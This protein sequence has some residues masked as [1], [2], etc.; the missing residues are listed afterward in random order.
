MANCRW[1]QQ[2]ARRSCGTFNDTTGTCG[3]TSPVI[4]RSVSVAGPRRIGS[5]SVGSATSGAHRDGVFTWL[6]PAVVALPFPVRLVIIGVHHAE[7]A[8]HL[9][10]Y[11]S[12]AEH[13]ELWIPQAIDWED[14][15]WLQER[16]ADFDVGIATPWRHRYNYPNR[17]SKAKAV[18]EQRC[19]GAE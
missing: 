2:E 13:V 17:V 10:R 3:V 1:Y 19:A 18:H 4:D 8:D 14:E 16:I 7:D 11:I 15:A 12:R 5:P 6:L 9:T